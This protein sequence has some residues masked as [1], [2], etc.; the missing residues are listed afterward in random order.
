MTS[1]ASL[2]QDC[3][4]MAPPQTLKTQQS[5]VTRPLNA[6]R[7]PTVSQQM[8]NTFTIASKGDINRPKLKLVK[9]H[10][11]RSVHLYVKKRNSPSGAIDD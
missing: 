7:T 10:S 2:S 8:Q 4:R 3:Q 5:S 11:S 1:I 9:T 6:Q